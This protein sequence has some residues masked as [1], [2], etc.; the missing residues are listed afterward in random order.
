ME[1]CRLGNSGLEVSRLG[2]G[3]IPFGTAIDEE[4][5]RRILDLF[6][7]LGGNLIDTSNFYG[8]GSRGTNAQMAGTSERTIGKLVKGRR[9]QFVIATKGYWMMEDEVR[10]NGVGLSRTYL[11]K[12][13]NDSLKRLDTDYIDLYQCQNWDLYT[14]VE[15]TL[16]VLDDL[17]RAGKIRYY[18][19]SNWDGW[20]VVKGNA[21]AG[22]MEYG[23]IVSNQ[24]WYNLADRTAEHAII[25]ACRDQAVSIIAFSALAQG[26]FSGLYKEGGERS[27]RAETMSPKLE[28][29]F[30]HWKNLATDRNWKTLDV[31]RRMAQERGTSV[32]A[33][34]LRWLLDT[35]ACDVVLMGM[36][37]L[38]QFEEN[39]RVLDFQLSE[40]E[41]I[42]LNDVSKPVS[43]YPNNFYDLFCRRESEFYGGLR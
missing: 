3:T 31:L 27:P 13:I 18:G 14:P 28:T 5:C 43:P 4:E 39:M 38:E 23:P 22:S 37:G 1:Y 16:R 17:V 8:G 41:K 42:K 33:V 35:G 19:V 32:P 9:E 11:T 6:Q 36:D 29:A 40:E 2:I 26:F 7:G 21:Y 30:F 10:P 20:H 15:E 34:A 25:P 24:I 12:N